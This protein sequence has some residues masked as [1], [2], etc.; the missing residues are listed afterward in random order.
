V[1]CC[2]DDEAE[3]ARRADAIGRDV[4]ELRENGLAG[5]PDEVVDKIGRYA[6]VGAQRVYLQVL[7]LS[8]LDHLALVADKVMPQI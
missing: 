2:G 6:E 1:L 8:D 5:S 7:D 4:D 3:I